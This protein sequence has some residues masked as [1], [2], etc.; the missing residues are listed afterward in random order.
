[1]MDMHMN[2]SHPIFLRR[3]MQ[4]VPSFLQW[5]DTYVELKRRYLLNVSVSR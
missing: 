2:A 3:P 4:L 5:N 1:M